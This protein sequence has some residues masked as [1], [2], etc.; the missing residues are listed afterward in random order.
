MTN[1][2]IIIIFIKSKNRKNAEKY[3]LYKI[4]PINK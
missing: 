2:T 4:K 1:F 3:S